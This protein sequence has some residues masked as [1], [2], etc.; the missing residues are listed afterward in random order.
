MSR[1]TWVW[2]AA[3]GEMILKGGNQWRQRRG[4]HIIRDFD[5]Y[6][7]NPADGTHYGTR[8]RYEAATRRAGAVEIGHAEHARLKERT[9]PM[10]RGERPYA[11]GY[12]DPTPDIQRAMAIHG[13]D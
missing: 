8:P 9:E 13:W 7:W 5:D 1:E 4:L 12:S 6:V 3:S 2:D 10:R 11:G